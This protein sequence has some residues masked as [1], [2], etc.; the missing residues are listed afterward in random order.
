[1]KSARSEN[2][3][4]LL[5]EHHSSQ[6]AGPSARRHQ[7][8]PMEDH[9]CQC[10]DRPE[11]GRGAPLGRPRRKRPTLLVLDLDFETVSVE[12]R[13]NV[14]S[15]SESRALNPPKNLISKFQSCAL[16]LPCDG[17]LISALKLSSE[18]PHCFG[19]MRILEAPA[20]RQCFHASETNHESWT[21]ILQGTPSMELGNA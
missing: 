1:M 3:G 15:D 16:P 17:I 20:S 12:S 19:N 4:A 2:D 21:P 8:A 13:R 9:D 11:S 7:N 10:H 6:T 5:T 18:A 14:F